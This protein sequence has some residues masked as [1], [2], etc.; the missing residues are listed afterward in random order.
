MNKKTTHKLILRRNC[1][2]FSDFLT[3]LAGIMYFEDNN[4]NYYIDWQNDLY[5][6]HSLNKNLFD[7]FFHQKERDDSSFDAIH[8]NT[9]PY[10]YFFPEIINLISEDDI[11]NFLSKPSSILK[12]KIS[13]NE[14][15]IKK[16]DLDLFKDQKVLGVHRRATDHGIHGIIESDQYVINCIEHELNKNQYDKLFLITDDLNFFE[17]MKNKYGNFLLFTDS[18][19]V[20]GS[21]GIHHRTDLDK[22]N[23]AYEVMRDA[24]LFSR[25]DYKILTKSNVSTFA[26][27]LNLKKNSFT[28][29]D[30][31]KK[32]V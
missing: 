30:K 3:I 28:Y 18:I 7:D 21:T 23:L 29:I 19:K 5:H 17:L 22:N 11:F 8:L 16:I 24:I 4:I 27:L 2:L 6:S 25:T 12:N 31:N 1:G 20:T 15:L 14:E 32:Y 10:G 13:F 26:N 9:T